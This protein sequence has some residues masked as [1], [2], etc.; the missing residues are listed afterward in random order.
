MTVYV[1]NVPQAIANDD[2]SAWR[3]AL[4]AA[5]IFNQVPF[6]LNLN[7]PAFPE[8]PFN[9]KTVQCVVIPEIIGIATLAR[10]RALLKDRYGLG[11]K[12]MFWNIVL[13]FDPSG[14]LSR[15]FA[16]DCTHAPCQQNYLCILGVLFLGILQYLQ[17]LLKLI[18][19][20]LP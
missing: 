20:Y 4:S 12:F 17:N 6:P 2:N 16:E 15:F 8:P 1:S 3:H 18:I 14:Q 10:L 13:L 11:T 19:Y 9:Q 5:W 7:F